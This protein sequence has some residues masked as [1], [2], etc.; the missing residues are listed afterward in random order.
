MK[1]RPEMS[2]LNSNTIVNRIVQLAEVMI[3]YNA[4]ANYDAG[5][6]PEMISSAKVFISHHKLSPNYANEL[7]IIRDQYEALIDKKYGT[8]FQKT[9]MISNVVRDTQEHLDSKQVPQRPQVA[10]GLFDVVV[11]KLCFPAMFAS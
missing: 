10:L 7:I 11:G 4:N 6:T 8:N 5:T 3:Q 2:K 9:K 1:E